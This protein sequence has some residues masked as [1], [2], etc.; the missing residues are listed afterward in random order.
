MARR[1]DYRRTKVNK[2]ESRTFSIFLKTWCKYTVICKMAKW[3]TVKVKFDEVS[4]SARRSVSQQV[5][6][7]SFFVFCFF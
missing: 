3:R 1:N 7:V 4:Q 5:P 2:N 6:K